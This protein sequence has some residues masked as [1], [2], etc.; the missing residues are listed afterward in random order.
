MSQIQK[1]VVINHGYG[2]NP[3]AHWFPWLKKELE[4]RGFEV[5]VPQMPNP[6]APQREVWVTTIAEVIGIPDKNTYFVGHS[7]GC[8]SILYYLEALPFESK[9]G[10]CV[11][12]GGF[13]KDIG[14]K[15]INDFIATPPD[16]DKVKAQTAQFVAII[17][18]TDGKVP[19]ETALEFQRSLD[20]ELILEQ[21]MGHF[22][23]DDGVIYLEQALQSILKMA[24]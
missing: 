5:F 24:A 12:V 3:D 14:K 18:R 22:T 4:S 1:R 23:S 20:A 7:L 8:V 19:V 6:D 13:S 16:F 15:E 17:S 11:F 9:V 21:N 10:G 2:S